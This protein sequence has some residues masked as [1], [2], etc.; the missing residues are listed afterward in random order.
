MS[1]FF[2]ICL[3]R[4]SRRT[5]ATGRTKTPETVITVYQFEGAIQ[6]CSYM[7]VNPELFAIHYDDSEMVGAYRVPSF[8]DTQEP[9][10][11]H[12]EVVT[13]LGLVE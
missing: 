6:L 4:L 7:V 13:L 11:S 9:C 2:C 8:M 10:W 3:R 12:V 5:K 1:L